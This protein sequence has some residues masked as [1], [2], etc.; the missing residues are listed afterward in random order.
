MRRINKILL[1][2]WI[3]LLL[4]IGSIMLFFHHSNEKKG[5]LY[6]VGINRIERAMEDGRFIEEL[7]EEVAKGTYASIQKLAYL[8]REASRKEQEQ[9]FEGK[10]VHL[11]SQYT[12]RILYEGDQQKGFLRYEY[13]KLK[14]EAALPLSM[15]VGVLLFVGMIVSILLVYVKCEILRP[16]HRIEHM[17]YELARG[18]YGYE[19]KES[20]SKYFGKFLWGLDRL[21]EEVAKNRERQ[22]ALEKEKKLLILSVSHDIKTP[23]S[24]IY[25]YTEALASNLYEEEERRKQICMQIQQKVTQIENFIGEI[26]QMSTN[27]LLDIQVTKEEHYIHEFVEPVRA[28]Y[29]EKFE[30]H[31]TEFTIG[32]YEDRLLG[33]DLDR[34]LEV[35]QN[36][37]ENA[38]KYGDGR[39]VNIGFYEEDYCQLIRVYSSGGKIESRYF[40]HLFE[41]FWRGE[42]AIGKKGSGLG[43]YICKEI[44][45]KLDGEIFVEEE[46]DGIVFVLVFPLYS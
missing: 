33:V 37:L 43:L 10:G 2:F 13:E 1:L 12:I 27:D 36:L 18:N 40:P 7:Q 24:S 25:L 38:M 11:E 22:L 35:F 46:E 26:E 16:F 4:S 34:I 31:K 45:K 8:G 41:S 32:P 9:F 30:L 44:M 17:A 39:F 5:R 14:Q 28:Q 15:I 42:N 3:V 29:S 6:V 20:K 21:R 23:L 19:V